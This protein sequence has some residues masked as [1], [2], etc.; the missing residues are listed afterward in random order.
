MSQSTQQRRSLLKAACTAAA[1]AWV[2]PTG[3]V[4]ILDSTWRAE[5]GRKGQEARG[6]RAH[7]QLAAQP[8]FRPVL[9]L[10][11][12]GS[13]WGEASCTWIGNSTQHAYLL[14]AAHI[15]EGRAQPDDYQVRGIDGR[16]HMPDRVWVHEEWNGEVEERAGFDLA[17]LRVPTPL[18]GM[19]PAPALY[20]G[21]G[22][23]GRLITFVGYGLRGTGSTGEDERID[24]GGTK[25]AA[26]GVVDEWVGIKKPR[27]GEDRGNTLGIF[28]PREDGSIPNP[29]GGPERPASRLV[30]LLGA[31]DSGGSAW[32]N[33]GGEWVIVGVNSNGDGKAGYGDSS[34]FTRVSSHRRWI[35][36]VFAGARFATPPANEP[37]PSYLFKNGQL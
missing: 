5:G 31:G 8:P 30:G 11:S 19:G 24:T 6:F 23:I 27:R 1:A 3:A 25:A 9:A 16:V 26:Q 29:F 2:H 20:T 22:E 17:I 32:M 37:G 34:W 33:S 28:M 10:A 21:Q 12:D 18:T 35:S 7:V 36:R 15:F 13:S 4:T 14:T